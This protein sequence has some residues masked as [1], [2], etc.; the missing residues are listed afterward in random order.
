MFF[1]RPALK[2]VSEYKLFNFVCLLL[3][4]FSFRKE[5]LLERLR[6]QHCHLSLAQVSVTFDM[7]VYMEA[8]ICLQYFKVAQC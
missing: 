1:T 5:P 6:P 2:Y 7:S 4:F 3:L 8:L